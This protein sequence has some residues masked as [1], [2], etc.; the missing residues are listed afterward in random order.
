MRASP[1]SFCATPPSALFLSE[2]DRGFELGRARVGIA[3]GR[4]ASSAMWKSKN[5]TKPSYSTTTVFGFP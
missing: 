4:Y 3:V 5:L 2:K 1:I